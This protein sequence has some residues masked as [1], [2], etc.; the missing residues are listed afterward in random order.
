MTQ[1]ET[2]K[3][4]EQL[5][6]ALKPQH[7]KFADYYLNDCKLNAS[8][9]ARKA[10]YKD[11]RQGW[12]ILRMAD[13]AAYVAA[14]MTATPDVMSAGEVAAR[15]TIEAR[16][17]VDLDDYTSVAPTERS[18][19]VP[20]LEHEPVREL[21]KRKACHPD[22]L[23]LYDLEG[24]FGAENVSRTGDQETLIR[25]ATIEQDVIID[26][27]KLKEAG[28]MSGLAMIKK[29]K[30]GSI[31]YRVKD[32]TKALQLLGQLHDLFGQRQV[33]QNPDG[34]PIKFIVG[35]AEDDL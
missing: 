18:F 9:A 14:L 35:M 2:P 34:S 13:V 20:A 1:P 29:N 4:V 27:A 31:E 26:W 3:T 12:R 11:H 17:T 30:D 16:N 8:A 28:G 22:D 6:A 5:G 25:V 23:D 7:K 19:W 10:G 21:A 33:H 24:H 32:P 15:L